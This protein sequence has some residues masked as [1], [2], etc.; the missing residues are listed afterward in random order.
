V[1]AGFDPTKAQTL[2]KEVLENP[3]MSEAA[4]QAIKSALRGGG[5]DE[6][7]HIISLGLSGS[8]APTNLQIQPGIKGGAAS[9]SDKLEDSLIEQ[10]KQGR[11][12]LIDAQNQL[13][14]AKGITLPENSGQRS[15]TDQWLMDHP[16][17][18]YPLAD[19][20]NELT[21]SF[22]QLAHPREFA[23]RV[24]GA[25]YD[26][27]AGSIENLSQSIADLYTAAT[28]KNPQAS[29]II[30]KGLNTA[31]ST[32]NTFISPVSALFSM[33]GKMPGVAPAE[34]A[35][36]AGMQAVDSLAHDSVSRV[37]NAIPD[38][39]MDQR[40]KKNLTDPISSTLS[41][42][43]QFGLFAK[44][45]PEAHAKA[46]ATFVKDVLSDTAKEIADKGTVTPEKASEIVDNAKQSA[47]SKVKKPAI[48]PNEVK[49]ETEP[50][51]IKPNKPEV[52]T[53]VKTTAIPKEL[54]PLAEEA[55]KYKSADEFVRVVRGD[56]SQNLPYG[57]TL[58]KFGLTEQSSRLSDLGAG[59]NPEKEVT[60]Y[61]GI[62]DLSGKV[63]RRINDG[64]YVI[65]DSEQAL[66]YTDSPKNVVAKKVK[67]K[68][69]I[70]QHADDAVKDIKQYGLDNFLK[71][72]ELIYSDS[73]NP[74]LKLNREQLT[75]FY[76]Q[77]KGTSE[78]AKIKPN[79]ETPT[80]DTNETKVETPAKPDMKG[81][82]KTTK[83]AK[84][85]N[86]YLVKQGFDELPKEDQA[87]YTPIT[88]ADQLAK[89]SD[90]LKN[91]EADA[92]EM[93]KG[94]KPIPDG[95]NP[96]VLF[97]AVSKLASS[98]NDI[99]TLMDLANSPLAQARSEAAQ[100]LGASGFN[101]DDV[102]SNIR[103][104]EQERTKAVESKLGT[105]VKKA[106]SDIVSRAKSEIN[107]INLPKEELS[108]DK[109]LNSIKC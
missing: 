102:V 74:V 66:A 11:M 104:V 88:K 70:V 93:A 1:A 64:D 96:Q 97:N 60:V 52:S 9:A 33:A 21:K 84:D 22:T 18:L 95:V 98:K 32:M 3:R 63:K 103:K 23:D 17:I 81:G 83:V 36:N 42:I 46:K 55:R 44:L 77:V 7:D 47:L 4:S 99:Q 13:A 105:K 57:A 92:I 51:A 48:K 28:E 25:G 91:N 78:P 12:S 58:R 10:V 6:L 24:L 37:I 39:V 79:A 35:M 41:T 49:P 43:A 38:K 2:P 67:I 76:N 8:N 45:S 82:T 65:G 75:D 14:K 85:I 59:I 89:V 87:K 86:A 16:D 107:K 19:A 20:Q 62:D 15:K 71:S 30:G 40:A 106:K 27:I 56:T 26:T 61:R 29:N 68:D 72:S 108:W 53:S 94:N 73:K 50:L 101:P 90:I 54:E 34:M 80:I 31:L 100:T 109:F 5:T 69:L